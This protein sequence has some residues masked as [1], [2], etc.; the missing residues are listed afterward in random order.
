MLVL[1]LEWQQMIILGPLDERSL[2]VVRNIRM[3]L[4]KFA[5]LCLSHDKSTT[6]RSLT[7]PFMAISLAS[8]FL[9]L[10]ICKLPSKKSFGTHITFFSVLLILALICFRK[11]LNYI[12]IITCISPI[13]LLDFRN[14][15]HGPTHVARRLGRSHLLMWAA[16]RIPPGHIHEDW[17]S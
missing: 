8:L 2:D 5:A 7:L 12:K 17:I 16:S 6:H 3:L 13:F 9:S 1:R 14:P 4:A 11:R 15:P 10:L